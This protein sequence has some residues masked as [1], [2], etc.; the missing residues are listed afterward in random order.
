MATIVIGS[1]EA[2]FFA[3]RG[4]GFARRMRSSGATQAGAAVSA[5][6]GAT[7]TSP[8]SSAAAVT[9]VLSLCPG[10]SLTKMHIPS[11]NSA[12]AVGRRFC[13]F[14][15]RNYQIGQQSPY[16]I[17]N[18]LGNVK[19]FRGRVKIER[20]E[21]RPKPHNAESVEKRH[22]LLQ[23]NPTHVLGISAQGDHRFGSRAVLRVYQNHVRA[24]ATGNVYAGV[25]C[26]AE[27]VRINRAHRVGCTRLP[28]HQCRLC[29]CETG[30]QGLDHFGSGAA[31]FDV[32]GDLNLHAL[33]LIGECLLQSR[34]V[35]VLRSVISGQL[36]RAGT[37]DK[38][39][40]FLV[41]DRALDFRERIAGFG[42]M[43]C[44]AA[45]RGKL[46]PCRPRQHQQCQQ[47]H[48]PPHASPPANPGRAAGGRGP[49]L[50][51]SAC[52]YHESMAAIATMIAIPATLTAMCMKIR[53]E[54]SVNMKW[55]AKDRN[56]PRQKVSRECWPQTIAG[57]KVRDFKAGQ[58][59]GTRA[60]VITASDRK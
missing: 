23:R 41:R 53:L 47:K 3:T 34:R 42:E 27:L 21:V 44:N 59:F 19:L 32:S 6:A 9:D 48:I 57:H 11:I 52:L 46:G 4:S 10:W 14:G 8:A 56:T 16:A 30:R 49:P 36:G 25:E 17:M 43:R 55:P 20:S 1:P 15:G 31:R 29:G 45:V 12:A 51:R 28:N 13:R 7:N 38:N 37:D 35:C 54:T 58:S 50:C 40:Q 24:G 2:I 5:R 60:T 18:S 26:L 39:V 22:F 33:Q